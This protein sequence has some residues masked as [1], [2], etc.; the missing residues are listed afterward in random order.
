MQVRRR[1]GQRHPHHY[2]GRDFPDTMALARYLAW[3]TGRSTNT[4]WK[5]LQRLDGD[6]AGLVE[7]YRKA[8][9][10]AQIEV[11][12]RAYKSQKAFCHHLSRYYGISRTTTYN[13]LNE[14]GAEA[15]VQRAKEI[16]AKRRPIRRSAPVVL[17]G[18]R[19]RSFKAICTY[20][21]HPYS[22]AALARWRKHLEAGGRPC[23][24]FLSAVAKLWTSG[25]LDERNRWP[26]EFEARLPRSCLPANAEM[27]PVTDAFEEK[28]VDALQPPDVDT[29]R[30]AAL[31]QL[32]SWRAHAG[33]GESANA[34]AT[35]APETSA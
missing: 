22:V 15:T 11:G 32:D 4:C 14:Y 21:R 7:R 18:W 2:D 17:F 33:G 10:A 27:E 12:G 35:A 3:K 1:G 8:D 20:Y 23:D 25:E 9:A 19:F 28:L 16:R 6:A 24:F 13:W 26:A 30:R 34:T 29:A 5:G 31:R